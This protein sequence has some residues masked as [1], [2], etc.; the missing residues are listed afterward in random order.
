MGVSQF[1][2]PTPEPATQTS[3]A[4]HDADGRPLDAPMDT[5]TALDVVAYGSE[6]ARRAFEPHLRAALKLRE[7][8]ILILS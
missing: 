1:L 8:K 6:Q 7:M 3:F 5:E 4:V 2:Q